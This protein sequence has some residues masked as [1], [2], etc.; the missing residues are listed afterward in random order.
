MAT[1]GTAPPL[2]MASHSHPLLDQEST[3]SS[4]LSSPQAEGHDADPDDLDRKSTP[5]DDD[6]LS[7]PNP[8]RADSPTNAT[9]EDSDLSDLETNS[10]EAETERLYHTPRKINAQ[11]GNTASIANL[12]HTGSENHTCT[13]Q[14]S[15]SKLHEQIQVGVEADSGEED[16]DEAPPTSR[17]QSDDSS[18]ARK[19]KRSPLV[20]IDHTDVSEPP[21]KR[22]GS[23]LDAK[24]ES[25]SLSKPAGSTSDK[26]AEQSG[27]DDDSESLATKD[28]HDVV[29]IAP[30]R[31]KSKRS[32]AKKRKESQ[33]RSPEEAQDNGGPLPDED[34][35]AEDEPIATAEVDEEA[36]HEEEC[37]AKSPPATTTWD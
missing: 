18:V 6:E 23:I 21:R 11:S 13:F 19:R 14:I 26:S 36:R 28:T 7:K 4:P 1:G 12:E 27:D 16:N 3:V 9:H 25:S 24:D 29:K 15:P 17:L 33:E 2:I 34:Q 37:K 31:S 30:V 22:S 8:P 35:P 10:S 5:S 32:H 20:L